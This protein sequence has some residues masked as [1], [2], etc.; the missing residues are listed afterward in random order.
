MSW[1]STE[2]HLADLVIYGS[3]VL[4]IAIAAVVARRGSGALASTIAGFAAG[5]TIVVIAFLTD[6]SD[7]LG[8]MVLAI[9]PYMLFLVGGGAFGWVLGSSLRPKGP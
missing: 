1:S 9:V 4:S 2:E 3:P 6:L 8:P 5:M 7:I